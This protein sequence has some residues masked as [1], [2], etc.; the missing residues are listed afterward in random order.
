MPTKFVVVDDMFKVEGLKINTKGIRILPLLKYTPS[1]GRIAET[2]VSKRGL[3]PSLSLEPDS[4]QRA[5]GGVPEGLV[6][7]P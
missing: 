4:N 5:G 3:P 2:S 1:E 7:V 6:T